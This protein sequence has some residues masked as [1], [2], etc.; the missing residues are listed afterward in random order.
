MTASQFS[1]ANLPGIDEI[2]PE[3]INNKVIKAA[4]QRIKDRCS[5]N[6]SSSDYYTKH[7]SH[8]TY[9]KGW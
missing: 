6:A 7:T 9:S 1:K 3:A 2:H 5:T 4:L 8:S